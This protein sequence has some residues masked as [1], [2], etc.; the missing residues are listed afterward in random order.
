MGVSA[1]AAETLDRIAVTIGKHVITESE[2]IRDLRITAFLDQKPVDLSPAA[3][4]K[5]ADR[6]VDQ[7]LILQDA[8]LSHLTLPTET[9]AAALL[10]DL[11]GQY[12]AGYRA[13]LARYFVTEAEVADHLLQGLRALRFSELRF[14]P[15]IQISEDELREF[16]GTLVTGWKREGRSPIPTL[17]ESRETVEKMMVDQ[18]TLQS[19][20]RW[21]GA[22]R[23]DNIILYRDAVF[24]DPSKPA[25]K[26]VSK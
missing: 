15:E 10:E 23:T 4:R 12:G 20:D 19:L 25:P 5:S 2:V 13:S 7:F 17:E 9:D 3:K 16:Y 6:L 26:E 8:T 11:K 24:K 14:R 22:E 21:L 1:C 18:R